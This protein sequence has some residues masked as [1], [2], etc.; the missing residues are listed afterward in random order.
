MLAMMHKVQTNQSNAKK[1][2]QTLITLAGD[3]PK[4]T[5]N[6][7]GVN[8]VDGKLKVQLAQK[9]QRKADGTLTIGDTM[10]NK[11]GLKTSLVVH[12]LKGGINAG[13]LNITN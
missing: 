10:I 11:G 12:L 3:R 5:D 8:N 13:N 4:L 1:L 7:I 6:N 2:N 9:H